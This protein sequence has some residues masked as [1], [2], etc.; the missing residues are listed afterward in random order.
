MLNNFM[1]GSGNLAFDCIQNNRI[2][3]ANDLRDR[4]TNPYRINQG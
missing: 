3:F 2:Q 1:Q 4:A